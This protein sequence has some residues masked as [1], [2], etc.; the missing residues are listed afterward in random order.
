MEKAVAPGKLILSGE[1]AVVYGQ[2]ALAMAVNRYAEAWVSQQQGALI[3]FDLLNLQY[4]KSMTM[5]ALRKLKHRVQDNYA[6]FLRGE[7][8]IRDVLKLPIELSQYAFTHFLEKVNHQLSDG[9]K[10]S[11]HSTIPIGCGM[12]SSAAMILCIM[13][14][15]AQQQGLQLTLDNYIEHARETESL[16]HG[17]SSGVDLQVSL[18]GG[19][20]R[21]QD[22]TWQ[23][24]SLPNNPFY[25][26]NTGK[27]HTTTGECVSAVKATMQDAALLA[28]FA[29][30]TEAMD[31]AIASQNQHEL[32]RCVREN[33]RLLCRIG[34]VPDKVQ[35]FIDALEKTGAAAKICGAGAVAGD[36][37]GVVLIVADD[38]PTRISDQFGY[39]S[40]I[41]AG[42][43]HGLRNV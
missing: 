25:M 41:I 32:Q 24:R 34:V 35:A 39:Q 19:C 29:D 27:P 31:A 22:G 8:H 26:V 13:H 6:A 5:K 37:A 21:F 9:V 14:A 10:L 17:R 20:M 12:G 33:H 43:A 40:E 4:H 42:E 23:A 18:R 7:A 38:M 30:I 3:G 1:H 11:T 15:V 16:Q 2:P 28:A 36:N